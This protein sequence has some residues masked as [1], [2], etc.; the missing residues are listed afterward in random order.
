MPSWIGL[1]L[2]TAQVLSFLTAPGN[3]TVSIGGVEQ[4]YT[5]AA[6]VFAQLFPLLVGNI[7]ASLYRQGAWVTA[8]ASPWT[9]TVTP[10]VQDLGYYAVSSGRTPS[11]LPPTP[12]PP[13]S[14]TLASTT[15]TSTSG[16]STGSTQTMTGATTLTASVPS[17]VS[18][19]SMSSSMSSGSSSST[20]KSNRP[21]S[22]PAIVGI[23]IGGAIVLAVIIGALMYLLWWRPN[24]ASLPNDYTLEM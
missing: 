3:I 19:T 24:H 2:I 22:V 4:T 6:G 10:Y 15:D 8:V 16:G 12:P 21:L 7:S 5:A 9:V 14:V 23:A 20:S 17:D 1:W 18:A 11:P 13:P